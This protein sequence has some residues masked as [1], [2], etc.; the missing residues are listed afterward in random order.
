[1]THWESGS[2][3]AALC[4]IL[5]RIMMPSYLEL[6]RFI[7]EVLTQ[8]HRWYQ[9]VYEDVTKHSKTYT[10]SKEWTQLSYWL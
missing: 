5:S 1:M 8:I 4:D 2:Y 10:W 3:K 7:A 9:Y 6:L